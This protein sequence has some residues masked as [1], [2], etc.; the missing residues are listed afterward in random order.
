M[1]EDQ[2]ENYIQH[3]PADD[4]PPADDKEEREQIAFELGVR[5]GV[6]EVTR[7]ELRSKLEGFEKGTRNKGWVP[8]I[9][10][11]V[12]ASLLVVG[13]LVYYFNNSGP[14]LFDQ[15]YQLHPNF[16]VT[17]LRGDNSLTLEQQTFLY[18]DKRDF[19]QALEGFDQLT[20]ASPAK[21]SLFFFRGITQ[22]ELGNLNLALTDLQKIINNSSSEYYDASLWYSSLVHLRLDQEE[23]SR[24]LLVR[25]SNSPGEY[26]TKAIELIERL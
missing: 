12:A 1:S 13:S 11:S 14:T 17:I 23:Q 20:Q 16:E 18:Y 22:I 5:E 26:Q 21:E 4:I 6:E 9:Y 10:G 19:R 3:N 25:L 7:T 2:R 24:A 15:Y 8:W